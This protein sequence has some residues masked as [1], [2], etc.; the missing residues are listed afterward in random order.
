MALTRLVIKTE[1]DQTIQATTDTSLFN[2][3]Q[4]SLQR[5]VNWE[6]KKGRGLDLPQV[7]FKGGDTRT[8]SLSLTFDSYESRKDVRNLTREV[9]KLAEV[10][11]GKDRPPVCT[12]TWGPTVQPY[13]GLPFQGVLESLT[14]KFTLFL[15]DGTPVRATMDLQFKAVEAPERQL[16]RTKRSRGSPLQPRT[17]IVKQGDSLWS[18]AAAEYR[19]PARWRAIAQ[20]N[21]ILN[22]RD[23]EPGTAL[24]LPSME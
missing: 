16:K 2:P 8:F 17:H 6:E 11:D 22:P 20:A 24:I 21:G 14:Q 1:D 13:A 7:Q 12:I 10:P 9:A 5:K 15:D 4:Y 3:N 23:L 18:I 19:D